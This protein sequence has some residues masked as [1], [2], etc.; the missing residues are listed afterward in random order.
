MILTH[1]AL[2]SFLNGAGSGAI[3]PVTPSVPVATFSGGS[4]ILSMQ[5]RKKRR[6]NTDYI[7]L[8]LS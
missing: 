6:D 2:F 4:A 1:L 3:P 7:L 8:L 5:Q